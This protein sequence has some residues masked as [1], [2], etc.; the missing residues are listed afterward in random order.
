MPQWVVVAFGGNREMKLRAGIVAVALVVLAT[1]CGLHTLTPP[2]PAPLRYRDQV[3]QNVTKT[4][5]VSYG[6]AVDQNGATQDLKLDIYEPTGDANTK[7]PV[8]VWVHGGGFSGGDKTSGEI[9]SEAT[10]MAKKGYF[11]VSINYRLYGPGC[12]ASGG[13]SQLGCIQAMIDAQHDAQAAVRFLRKNATTYKID[14]DRIA[15]GGS[16]AGAIT[17]LHVAANSEDPGTSGNPGFS[18]AIK[19]A[20]SLSG[21]KI[22]GA[23]MSSTDAP[24]LMFHGTNDGLVPY[25]WAVNTLDQANAANV[26][27]YL[28]TY[29]GDGHVPFQHYEQIF[30]QQTNFL[31]WVLDLTHAS[32]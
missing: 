10:D 20:V 25:Q 29:Q 14:P 27:A 1:G 12:S 16:S 19:G 2:G 31:Y 15:M 21:A 32:T 6:S 3:F 5:D 17:A 11:N 30:A 8:M 26:V 4:A 7:R 9:V 18:S 23:P 28:T 22:I 24:I 13:G